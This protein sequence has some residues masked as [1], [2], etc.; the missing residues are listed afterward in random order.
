MGLKDRVIEYIESKGLTVQEF[1][2]RCG[3]SNGAVSKMGENT[4]MKTLER[5][6][7]TF[8]DLD[9]SWLRIGVKKHTSDHID[10]DSINIPNVSSA[11]P[12]TLDGGGGDTTAQHIPFYQNLPVSGGQNIMYPEILN[13]ES[14]GLIN[15]PFAKG[16]ECCFPVIG[17]SM[18]PTINEGEIIGVRH[19]ETYETCNPDRVYMITT[20]DNE[21]MIKRI[22]KYDKER[23][24]IQLCSDNPHYSPF[25]LDE[26]MIIDVYKVLW[27]IKFETL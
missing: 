16:A 9:V 3:L 4:R 20:R 15:L 21:R 25:E 22:V 2:S 6:S 18:A 8:P 14:D 7:N 1:E 23:G 19:V 27:H 10:K 11:V 26:S 5:I 13:Q 12:K 24:K 17:M